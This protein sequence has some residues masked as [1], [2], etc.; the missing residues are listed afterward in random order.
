MEH[1][2]VHA[3]VTTY[4]N[5]IARRASPSDNAT[6]APRLRIHGFRSF[7]IHRRMLS[8]ENRDLVDVVFTAGC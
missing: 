7:M 5:P 2:N 8:A 6:I 4:L 1:L 3:P